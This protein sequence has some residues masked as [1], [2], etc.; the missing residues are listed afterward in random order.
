MLSSIQEVGTSLQE[1]QPQWLSRLVMGFITLEERFCA[2][3]R[4]FSETSC[5]RAVGSHATLA[6]AQAR[7]PRQRQGSLRRRAANPAWQGLETRTGGHTQP[8]REPS[9][10]GVGVDS[11]QDR[12]HDAGVL[13]TDR[14]PG[15]VASSTPSRKEARKAR[16]KRFSRHR[17]TRLCFRGDRHFI[18][19]TITRGQAHDRVVL[20][21]PIQKFP[22]A[23]AHFAPGIVARGPPS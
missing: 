19:S 8:L 11:G 22:G 15:G 10:L 3:R 14:D 17:D 18:G 23:Q 4:V 13:K 2:S 21:G 9:G 6:W 1:S 16:R 20:F 7:H 5:K 12:R